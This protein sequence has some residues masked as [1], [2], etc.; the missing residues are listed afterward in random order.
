MEVDIHLVKT[1]RTLEEIKK[2]IS[3]EVFGN[4]DV[5]DINPGKGNFE[6]GIFLYWHKPGYLVLKLDYNF[7]NYHTFSMTV[8][9]ALGSALHAPYWIIGLGLDN[10]V[11]FVRHYNY[12]DEKIGMHLI[13]EMEDP[14]GQKLTPLVKDLWGFDLHELWPQ[15]QDK[16]GWEMRRQGLVKGIALNK[17][18]ADDSNIQAATWAKKYGRTKKGILKKLDK[19][20]CDTMYFVAIKD[21]EQHRPEAKDFTIEKK[22]LGTMVVGAP[23]PEDVEKVS[24]IITATPSNLKET[25]Q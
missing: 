23:D 8:M 25:I 10:P 2:I 7:Y 21:I 12:K 24:K 5:V 13:K 4:Y 16:T 14:N 9:T 11:A 17:F 19:R 20:I 15:F 18:H 22:K 3:T 1:D 6:F